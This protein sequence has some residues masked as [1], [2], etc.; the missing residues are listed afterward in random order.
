MCRNGILYDSKIGIDGPRITHYP[1]QLEGDFFGSIRRGYIRGRPIIRPTHPTRIPYRLPLKHLPTLE[2]TERILRSPLERSDYPTRRP[3]RLPLRGWQYYEPSL[4]EITLK[5]VRYHGAQ[6]LPSRDFIRDVY[7]QC[8]IRIRFDVL[9]QV[10]ERETDIELDGDTNLNISENIVNATEIQAVLRRIGSHGNN[11]VPVVFVENILDHRYQSPAGTCRFGLC[12][13]SN[14][15]TYPD[16]V[17]AH[18]VGHYLLGPGHTSNPRRLM[19]GE[20]NRQSMDISAE[21]CSIMHSRI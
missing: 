16:V 17:I 11:E 18:E 8:G 21:E 14:N 19:F 1:N 13:I 12:A 20:A 2:S 9:P 6:G 5:V 15:T 4:P 10:N 3:Y 7:H